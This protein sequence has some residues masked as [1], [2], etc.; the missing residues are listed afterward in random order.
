MEFA[1]DF[2][3][4]LVAFHF[5]SITFLKRMARYLSV[6]LRNIRLEKTKTQP[7]SSSFGKPSTASLQG[8]FHVLVTEDYEKFKRILFS[9]ISR[10]R[11]LKSPVS[12]VV[13]HL[14]FLSSQNRTMEKK[15]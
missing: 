8:D 7:P 12:L 9:E 2:Y 6:H 15:S 4:V 13:C 1:G 11:L 10:S 3:G 5:D 14:H